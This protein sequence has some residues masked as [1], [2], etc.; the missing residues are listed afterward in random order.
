MTLNEALALIKAAKRREG[1]PFSH[2]LVC[3]FEPLHLRTFLTARLLERLDG[4]RVEIFTGIYGDLT[5]N[6]TAAGASKALAAAVVIEWSDLDPRL[7]LRSAGG[8]AEDVHPDILAGA[9]QRLSHFESAI[10]RLAARMPAAVAGPSLP[11]SPLGNTIGAQASLVE[12][13]LRQLISA[14]LVRIARLP[15][16]RILDVSRQS[17]AAPAD[18]LDVRMELLVGF[19]YTPAF[20]DTLASDFAQVLHQRTPKKGLI[21]DLDDTLWSGIVGELGADKVTWQQESHTQAHG[22]Y[23]QMLSHLAA[24]GALL[25]VCSKNEPAVVQA[26]LARPDLFLKSESLYPVCAGWEPKSQAVGRILRTWNVGEDS[27]V[28]I[29]DSPMELEEVRRAYPGILCREFPKKDPAALWKLLC[30]LRDLFGK[31]SITQEDRLRL[32]SI[33]A[34]AAVQEQGEGEVAAGFLKELSATVT[35][36][37]RFDPSDRRPLE[38][39]N[40]TNQFNLNG[41]RLAEGEWR[42]RGENPGAFLAVASYTDK[43]GPLGKVAVVLG[44]NDGQRLRVSHWVMSCRAFSRR[45][46]HHTL[47]ALFRQT[48]AGE[49][50]F[51]YQATDRNQPLQEFFRAAGIVPDA[52]GGY[53]ISRASFVPP[54]TDLPH[55]MMHLR[56]ADPRSII[57]PTEAST[58][59]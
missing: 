26:A 11:L 43:F 2:F 16:V 30:E 20:A 7:G 1:E 55:R 50:E 34:S 12:L 8:W 46:E 24:C 17:G 6:L 48:G 42:R 5:G 45:I 54:E 49:I 14:F 4:A 39:I 36:D 19:P 37:W 33:R 56:A 15:G 9:A 53:R 41:L 31:P 28:F 57:N 51:A 10:V 40:K 44:E 3:G 22:L 23:Q 18:R 52:R 29:D 13:E 58:A 38:L 47:D 25:A 32:N 21:T 59:P 35:M 27:V